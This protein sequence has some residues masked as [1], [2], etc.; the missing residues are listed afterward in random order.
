MAQPGVRNLSRQFIGDD[1][2][3]LQS[4]TPALTAN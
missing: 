1:P 4:T 2:E 3:L